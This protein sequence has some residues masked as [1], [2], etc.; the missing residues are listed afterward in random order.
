LIETVLRERRQI[1]EPSGGAALQA[2]AA[3]MVLAPGRLSTT[4]PCG[5]RCSNA[6]PSARTI[7]SMAP[8]GAS[9]ISTLM[10]AEG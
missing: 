10:G 4:N 8:P 2:L 1:V 9:G 6:L 7:T 3:M 5:L